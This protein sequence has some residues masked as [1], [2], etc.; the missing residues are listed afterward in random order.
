MRRGLAVS[1]LTLAV[2]AAPA[3]A[4][5]QK[6]PAPK[7]SGSTPLLFAA[8]VD[9]QNT[10]AVSIAGAGE[11]SALG[12]TGLPPRPQSG[13]PTGK[14]QH[15]PIRMRMYY[16]QAASTAKLKTALRSGQTVATLST[17]DATLEDGRIESVRMVPKPD[18]HKS[19]RREIV[20]VEL[21]FQKIS[22]R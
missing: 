1:V 6:K 13:P 3:A 10:V 19:D 2:V 8:L 17:P 5:Q 21:V 9:N 22:W 11:V 15:M 12:L 14:R 7:P 16:D 18:S 20:E 4:A